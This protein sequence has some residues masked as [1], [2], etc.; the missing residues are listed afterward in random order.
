MSFLRMPRKSARQVISDAIDKLIKKYHLSSP[1]QM[2]EIKVTYP[3]SLSRVTCVT[4]EIVR[5]FSHLEVLLKICI[6]MGWDDLTR[7]VTRAL[8]IYQG[9]GEDQKKDNLNNGEN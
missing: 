1:D 9:R 2:I 7:K 3:S 5:T 8:T 4:D 6:D